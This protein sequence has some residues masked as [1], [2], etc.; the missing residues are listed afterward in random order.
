[1][2][3]WRTLSTR[4]DQ[5]LQKQNERFISDVLAV[6]KSVAETVQEKTSYGYD[7]FVP[8]PYTYVHGLQDLSY[9]LYEKICRILGM[10]R[11]G[12]P[13]VDYLVQREEALDIVA[14]GA[15]YVALLDMSVTREEEG[16]K[17]E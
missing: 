16:E 8:L 11:V 9:L 7:Q 14:Y 2:K 6:L 3:R 15:F 5:E 1:L 13:K 17:G 10:E 4:S 12:S